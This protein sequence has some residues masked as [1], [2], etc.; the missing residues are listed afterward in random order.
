MSLSVLSRK[1]LSTC[2][3]YAVADVVICRG[4]QAL[5]E[6]CANGVPSVASKTSRRRPSA[7]SARSMERRGATRVIYEQ[8]MWRVVMPLNR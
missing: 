3:V 1:T 5:N 7:H 4:G 8:S 6:V 2:R